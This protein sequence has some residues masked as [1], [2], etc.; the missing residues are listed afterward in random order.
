MSNHSPNDIL[1]WEIMAVEDNT[2]DLKFMSDV[3]KKAGYR[4]RSAGD[5]EL[6]L[7]SIRAKLPNLILM[8][9]AL[10]GMGGVEVCRRLKADPETREIP[11]I[12]ISAAG[13]SDLKVAALEA[14]GVDYVTKPVNASELLARIK[15]HLK[16]VQLQR[17]LALRSRELLREIEARKLTE[18]ALKKHQEGLEELIAAHMAELRVS[19]EK[20]SKAF[21]NAPLLMTISSVEDGRYLDV[22]DAFVRITGYAREKAVGER[23][24]DLGFISAENRNRLVNI[25]KAEGRISEL[26]LELTSAQGERVVCR[27]SGEII[28]VEGKRRL[29]SIAADITERKRAENALREST[30]RFQKV[31]DSQLDAIFVLDSRMPPRILECNRAAEKIFGYAA[32]EMIGE[33]TAKLHVDASYL[34]T[35]QQKLYKTLKTQDHLE[36]FEF[37]MKRKDGKIFPSKHTVLGLTDDPGERRGWISIVGD[38]TEQKKME[39]R[40]QRAQKMEAIGNLAGGIAHDFNNILFPIVGMAELLQEDLP[41][42]GLEYENV[43]MIHKAAE[44]GRRLVGQI[45]AFSRRSEHKMMLVR[46]QHIMK[47]VLGL[48]R[49]TIPADIQIKRFIQGDCGLVM[50][51][52]TQLHQVAMNLITNA[53][54]A[55]EQTGGTISVQLKE[56]VLGT[57]DPADLP[58][59]PGPYAMLSVSDTGC[60]MDSALMGKIFDPYFTTK[61]KE[62]GT[63]LGL[64]VVYGIVKEHGG[65]IRVQSR[66]GEGTTVEVYLPLLEDASPMESAGDSNVHPT[67]SERILL[68]DDEAQ[69]VHL[70][71]QILERLGYQVTPFTD[72]VDALG[73]FRR[74]PDAFDLVVTD[75]AMPNLAGDRLAEEL[76]SIRQNI[77]IIVC[78]GFSERI[79]EETANRNGI[80]GFLLKPASI[81]DLANLLRKTLDEA[82]GP[83]QGAIMSETGRGES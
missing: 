75:M 80:K 49:S 12:F 33:T 60:G 29:L 3:L 23:S 38:L 69:V 2:S 68:V 44:R 41:S 50:A 9:V 36:D 22:N 48:C 64:A 34:K 40:L 5:G 76:I 54:H 47:E 18:K 46:L 74:D 15:T 4:V 21:Q 77:P 11:V 62:K 35:F 66:L 65:D 57:G 81:S 30:V 7:R 37:S 19:K 17:G 67:G 13:K 14:G 10:P 25:L 31:F 42:G 71:K 1:P 53:Y 83:N 63:G 32:E 45:L 52:A 78:T 39:T 61:E 73:A 56:R 8:D 28:E 26:E 55:V 72:S 27:Y 43:K 59:N 79:D 20:F 24:V 6:A 70:E 82:K 58:L 51:D 16:I